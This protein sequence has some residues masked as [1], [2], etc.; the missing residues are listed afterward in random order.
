MKSSR[1]VLSNAAG[2]VVVKV[3]SQ[4]GSG[5]IV[6]TILKIASEEQ[7]DLILMGSSGGSL[8][9]NWL[10]ANVMGARE[11]SCQSIRTDLDRFSELEIN[12][13]AQQAV[14][15]QFSISSP[16]TDRGNNGKGRSS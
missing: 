10:S 9:E 5:D 7:T 8:V 14:T 11:H 4:T 13:Q 3:S 15:I 6:E 12:S 2:N 16:S 1:L